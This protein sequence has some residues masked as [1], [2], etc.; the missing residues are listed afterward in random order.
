MRSSLLLIS[1]SS[2][3]GCRAGWVAEQ[4]EPDLTDA[5]KAMN[6][7]QCTEIPERGTPLI[8]DWGS[9]QKADLEE[10]MR[11]DIA[12]VSY[13]CETLELLPDCRVQGTYGWMG[14]ELK[15]DVV[16]LAGLGEIAANLP[17]SKVTLQ[18]SI[19]R[20]SVLD[21]GLVQVGKFRS[22]VRSTTRAALQGE[23]DECARATHYVRGAY[24]GAFALRND[25][26]GQVSTAAELFKFSAGA[27]SESSGSVV[28]TDG[29][30]GR[31]S[32]AD[33]SSTRP[34]PGCGGILRLELKAITDGPQALLPEDADF[35]DCPAGLVEVDGKCTLAATATT[36]VCAST[37]A[38]DCKAQC[39]LGE[40]ASCG[41]LAFMYHYGRGLPMNL[42]LAADA[43]TRAC[44][45]GDH[46]GCAGLG[47]FLDR[48]IGGLAKDPKRAEELQRAACDAGEP[49]GCNNLAFILNQPGAHDSAFALYQRACAGGWTQACSNLGT[50]YELGLVVEQDVAEANRRYRLGCELGDGL[51][52]A[53]LGDSTW[54]GRGVEVNYQLAMELFEKGC[55]FGSPRACILLGEHAMSGPP[56]P[57]SSP[58]AVGCLLGA[59]DQ[60][61]EECAQH[62]AGSPQWASERWTSE[63]VAEAYRRGCELG[64]A[65]AC[66][67][68]SMM[69]GS[70]EVEAK[71]DETKERLHQ[72]ACELSP[73]CGAP[74]AD[75]GNRKDG[76]GKTKTEG[77]AK[78]PK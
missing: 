22:A 71:Q 6:E 50:F 9:H 4:V 62:T 46:F 49:R 42:E 13:D 63:L 21:L 15:Q 18:G 37:D 1:F 56:R 77:G 58:E 60:T 74:G 7:H 69:I 52:C 14:S 12:V 36:H 32:A 67:T 51:G 40:P 23:P 2:L 29:D 28:R 68:L 19:T 72:R 73:S 41:R 66:E 8:V 20:E 16:S 3:L 11:S 33:L 34:P 64:E 25:T 55:Q 5:A 26:F 76:G 31:C 54:N 78:P 57:E 70:G 35:S 39:D 38:V 45:G 44:N 30:P 17:T 10:I 27:K 65:I 53:N 48:G 75:G 61:A 24:V 59:S 47:Y 43:Y